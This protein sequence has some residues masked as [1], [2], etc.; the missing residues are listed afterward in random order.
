MTAWYV[1]RMDPRHHLTRSPVGES[2]TA[3]KQ[4]TAHS[5]HP[6]WGSTGVWSPRLPRSDAPSS[7]LRNHIRCQPV[8]AAHRIHFTGEQYPSLRY[9]KPTSTLRNAAWSSPHGCPPNLYRLSPPALSC[10]ILL[11]VP[12]LHCRLLRCCADAERFATRKHAHQHDYRNPAHQPCE[13]SC[14]YDHERGDNYA[15]DD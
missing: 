11:S 9:P 7:V 15:H 14:S 1:Y 5:I 3:H 8:W 6:I 4:P 2:P 13:S 10:N 12:H